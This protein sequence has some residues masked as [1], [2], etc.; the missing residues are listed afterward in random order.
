MSLSTGDQKTVTR[1]LMTEQCNTGTST[2]PEPDVRP[3]H[4]YA[5][6]REIVHRISFSMILLS[7][8]ITMIH[9]K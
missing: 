3:L 1:P 5:I 6:A 2:I 9:I 8:R 7:L 4:T